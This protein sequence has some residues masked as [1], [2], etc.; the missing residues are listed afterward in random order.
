MNEN[1]NPK[2]AKKK[3]KN[4]PE[5]MICDTILDQ[6]IFS[7][8]RNITKNNVLFRIHVHRESIPGK[9]PVRKIKELVD[10]IVVCSFQFLEWKK[11]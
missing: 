8:V 10:E 4:N 6:N 1:W 5:R 3:L 9:I 11:N 7:G 2:T